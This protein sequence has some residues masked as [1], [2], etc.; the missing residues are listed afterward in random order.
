MTVV[1]IDSGAV[2]KFFRKFIECNFDRGASVNDNIKYIK[3]KLLCCANDYVL[4]DDGYIL[5]LKTNEKILSKLPVKSISNLHKVFFSNS[6]INMNIDNTI[7]SCDVNNNYYVEYNITDIDYVLWR[8]NWAGQRHRQVNEHEQVTDRFNLITFNRSHDGVYF[9]INGERQCTLKINNYVHAICTESDYRV[10]CL[11]YD[12]TFKFNGYG[13]SDIGNGKRL[14]ESLDTGVYSVNV[15]ISK[16]FDDV[17]NASYW[18]TYLITD[19]YLYT[20]DFYDNTYTDK[21]KYKIDKSYKSIESN[22]ICYKINDHYIIR[23]SRN[24]YR[25]NLS[26]DVAKMYLAGDTIVCIDE[27]LDDSGASVSPKSFDYLLYY[28][29]LKKFYNT[30]YINGLLNIRRKHN[31]KHVLKY[32]K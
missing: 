26:K 17:T 6:F 27:S 3:G 16:L 15:R 8:E 28:N 25:V 12:N 9:Y 7:Y 18:K 22:V 24:C 11:V 1:N 13:P 32:Y 20:T 2:P 5:N 31:L 29:R 19:N 10:H 30:D 21:I 4:L 23:S 14:E